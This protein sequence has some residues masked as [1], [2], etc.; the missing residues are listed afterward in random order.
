[1][2][3]Y[4]VSI[5]GPNTCTPNPV[6]CT[7][8]GGGGIG[9]KAIAASGPSPD[10]VRVQNGTVRG[11]GGHGVRMLG[12]GTVVE[13]VHS[14]SNGGPGIVVGEGSV[15]D[16][17]VSLNASGAALVGTIVRGC[18][19]TN[20]VFGIFVRPGGV[21]IGNVAA[22]N[23]AGGI[24]VNQATAANNTANNNGDYGIDG[25]CPG[26]LVGNTAHNNGTINIKTNGQCTLANNNP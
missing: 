20:N 3:T 26:V 18:I 22:F 7:Y 2:L 4:R 12:N 1:M 9:V 16:S 15:I 23:A 8:S 13:R 6:Q 19:A 17:I 10:N 25:A 5:N 21:A 24:S 11:M 14:V